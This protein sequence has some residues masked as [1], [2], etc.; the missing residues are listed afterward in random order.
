[1]VNWGMVTNRKRLTIFFFFLFLLP[2]TVV[3]I[4]DTVDWYKT[5]SYRITVAPPYRLHN[6]N[7]QRCVHLAMIRSIYLVLFRNEYHFRSAK[8]ISHIIPSERCFKY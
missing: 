4:V 3:G 7:S 6:V 1:M 2:S 5:E 8:C